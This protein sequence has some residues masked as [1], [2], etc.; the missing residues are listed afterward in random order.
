VS[1]ADT[2]I[3]IHDRLSRDLGRKTLTDKELA[4]QLGIALP[5]MRIW[6][7]GKRNVLTNRQIANLVIAVRKNAE[8]DVLRRAIIPVVEFFQQLEAT[9]SRGGARWEIFSAV[10]GD[11]HPYPYLLGLRD[12]LEKHSGVYIFYDS[13]GRAIYVGKAASRNLWDELNNAFNRATGDVQS[14]YRVK[15]PKRNYQFKNNT[16]KV[17]QIQKRSVPIYELA[18]YLSAYAIPKEL[19]SKF[20]AL[21][22]RAF[23]NDLLNVRMEHIEPRLRLPR[24]ARNIRRARSR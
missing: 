4:S 16:E 8:K 11:G 19:I 22:V 7:R 21:L 5:T 14:I 15:H 1:A 9:R 17:R 23:A 10:A 20:E 13:S 2:I 24:A 6:K 12:E 18:K 3:A